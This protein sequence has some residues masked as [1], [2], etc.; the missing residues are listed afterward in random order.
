MY[1]QFHTCKPGGAVTGTFAVS[2][3][4]W[5]FFS[6]FLTT[7][8]SGMSLG[9]DSPG[10]GTD[11]KA[12][13]GECATESWPHVSL[14][15][16]VSPTPFLMMSS[17]SPLAWV[18]E[19]EREREGEGAQHGQRNRKTRKREPETDRGDTGDFSSWCN[20][21]VSG[22]QEEVKRRLLKQD[23]AGTSVFWQALLSVCL[24][25]PPSLLLSLS[26]SPLPPTPSSI[27]Q[28]LLCAQVAHSYTAPLFNQLL[29][30]L[31]M[32]ARLF[33]PITALVNHVRSPFLTN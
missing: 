33:R 14:P 24:L 31:I 6:A 5:D 28:H 13:F 18:R 21:E 10:S 15:C 27:I 25:L 30:L 11:V 32:C 22:Q 2:G 4:E 12:G 20:A 17:L 7:A 26:P 16:F 3:R 23:G 29:L 8:Y 1:L 9:V 19:R